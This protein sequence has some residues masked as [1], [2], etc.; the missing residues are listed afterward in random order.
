MLRLSG[1]FICVLLY[2]SAS[3]LSHYLYIHSVFPFS[4]ITSLYSSLFTLLTVSSLT[5]NTLTLHSSPTSLLLHLS[6][7]FSSYPL[8]SLLFLLLMSFS[9][10]CRLF[11][12]FLCLSVSVPHSILSSLN[13][14][15]PPSY[16]RSSF[17]F[18]LPFMLFI[19]FS[20]VFVC[21]LYLSHSLHRFLS[22]LNLSLYPS[23]PRSFLLFLLPFMLFIFFSRLFFCLLYLSVS[24]LHPF[25]SFFF[26]FSSFPIILFFLLPPLSYHSFSFLV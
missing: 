5:S 21:L 2:S 1:R 11:V 13:L 25:F 8:A 12:F 16:P 26:K 24:F 7:H 9:F 4:L 14:S 3:Y 23:Y 17:L 6:Y 19:F 10:F 18:L 15:L 22:S 20:R